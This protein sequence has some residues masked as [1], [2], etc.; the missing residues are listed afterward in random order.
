LGFAY[1][2]STRFLC[3]DKSEA[4]KELTR[5]RRQWFAKRKNIVAL[6]RDGL[7]LLPSLIPFSSRMG[8]WTV[9]F[10]PSLVMIGAGALMGLRVTISMFI[11]AATAGP[12]SS[13]SAILALSIDA[14][15]RCQAVAAFS[16]GAS[17]PADW[18]NTSFSIACL[19]CVVSNWL[20]VTPSVAA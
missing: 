9:G 12:N 8:G 5:L 20:A 2:W 16:I 18:R 15:A 13:P 19:R 14:L 11:A 4:E 7:S 3:L 17:S 6:L 1:R 10:E